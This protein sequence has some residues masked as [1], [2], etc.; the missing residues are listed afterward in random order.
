MHLSNFLTSPYLLI[1]KGNAS[2]PAS[3]PVSLILSSLPPSLPLLPVRI[4]LITLSPLPSAASH[5][6]LPLYIMQVRIVLITGFE[7][8]NLELYNRVSEL[9]RIRAPGTQLK[10]VGG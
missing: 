3:L 5:S 8:F 6:N 4:L 7:S 9:L 1:S 10:V 2:L